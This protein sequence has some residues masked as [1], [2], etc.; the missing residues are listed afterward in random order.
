M[1]TARQ[2]R[3]LR[4]VNRGL[5]AT[6]SLIGMLPEGLQSSEL[7]LQLAVLLWLWSAELQAFEFAC[8]RWL[9]Q[10]YRHARHAPRGR[11][12]AG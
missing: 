3:V 5:I 2:N 11:H 9:R 12:R 10:L 8:L 4:Q 7:I 6:L 1:T